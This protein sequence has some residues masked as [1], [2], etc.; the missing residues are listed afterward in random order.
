MTGI[1]VE[2]IRKKNGGLRI[3]KNGI[4]LCNMTTEEAYELRDR[5]EFWIGE[6]EVDN[7]V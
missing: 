4:T 7:N 2:N 5:I 3:R 6:K 1:T